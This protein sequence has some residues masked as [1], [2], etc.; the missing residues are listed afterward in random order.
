M[1]HGELGTTN[2]T[3]M[4]AAASSSA[5]T[6]NLSPRRSVDDRSADWTNSSGSAGALAPGTA[7]PASGTTVPAK[8][9]SSTGTDCR[10]RRG[11]S[12]LSM[13]NPASTDSRS[14][15]T[16]LKYQL[17]TGF[18]GSPG[19][20]R[21]C[22]TETVMPENRASRLVT[23]KLV[24]YPAPVAANPPSRPATGW[25]PAALNTI[26]ASGGMTMKLLSDMTLPPT[27]T[28]PTAYGSAQRGA[29][30]KIARTPAASRPVF[31]ATPTASQIVNTVIRGGK[32]MKFT[33]MFSVNQ[34][35]PSGVN[36]P[37]IWVTSSAPGTCT[38][39]SASAMNV[40]TSAMTKGDFSVR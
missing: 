22:V 10:T 37:W 29:D 21:I 2:A 11:S 12:T 1:R 15:E 27:P 25:R 4:T 36:S 3:A 7:L 24:E 28:K 30:P 13:R 39:T 26:A 5:A 14:A 9:A 19:L 34:V 38:L 20:G 32:P 35:R 17:D 23:T 6:A 31:S 40:E 8:R 16:T 18:T 33:P